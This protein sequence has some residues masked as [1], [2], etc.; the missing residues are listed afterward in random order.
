VRPRK[1]L[2]TFGKWPAPWGWLAGLVIA[3]S[4]PGCP[5]D[6]PPPCDGPTMAFKVLLV[7][8]EGPLPED[9]VFRVKHGS[10]TGTEDFRLDADFPSSDV[11]FCCRATRDGECTEVADVASDGD[12]GPAPVEGLL[13]ELWTDGAAQVN[14]S[15]S[16]YPDLDEMLEAR[17]SEGC[18]Q[19]VN[20]TLT[21]VRRDA[22]R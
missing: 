12:G 15:A 18:L 3:L 1:A 8:A 20:V 14:V 17:S 10:A 2:E 21:L 5:D 13:C 7:A 19:T 22:G 4:L 11:V 9:T 6:E 16:G